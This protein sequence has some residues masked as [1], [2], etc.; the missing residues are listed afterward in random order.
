MLPAHDL[1]A[2]LKLLVALIAGAAIGQ[3]RT[4]HGRPA[5]FRT[6]ALVCLGSALLIIYGGSLAGTDPAAASRIAQ[7]I[8]TGIGFLGAGVI[9][10]ERLSVHGLTTAASI[11][12]GAGLGILIGAG[13]WAPAALSWAAILV[14]LSVLRWIE[15][16]LP[17]QV[18][19]HLVMRFAEDA[20]PDHAGMRALLKDA[21][22]RA[23][24][25]SFRLDETTRLL[26]YRLTAFCF[27]PSRANEALIQRL[28]AMPG[29][30]GF[31][32]SPTD[33]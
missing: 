31:E 6:Y 29:L 7:G 8:M 2:V 28:R 21:G 1:D 11:W 23:G 5:G 9:F 3:E 16:R 20:A 18:F 4:Y 33:D 32:I 14:T 27:V 22:F 17:H 13:A 15:D 24:R 12:A 19:V 30:K 25:F 10:K 26:E